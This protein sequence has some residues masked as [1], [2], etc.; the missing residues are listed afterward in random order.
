MP[1]P[2][3]W[4]ALEKVDGAPLLFVSLERLVSLG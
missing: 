2:L 4:I 3:C 1:V